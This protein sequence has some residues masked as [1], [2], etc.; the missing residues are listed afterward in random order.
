MANFSP[1]VIKLAQETERKYGVPA[2]VTLAQYALESGYGTSKVA[3]TKN[4]YFG[5][6]K[7]NGD[8]VTYQS[9]ADS[10]DSHG[11]LLGTNK[12]YT[13]KTAGVTSANQYVKAIAGTYA[14]DP[15]YYNKIVSIMRSNN[16]YQYDGGNYTVEGYNTTAT[17][18]NKSSGGWFKETGEAVLG[19]I[20]KALA[21]ILVCILAV[22]FFMT[23]FDVKIPTPGKVAESND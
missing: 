11:R 3:K 21:I 5:V 10:F 4:N 16:L 6:R 12:I 17:T 8:Y 20:I 23:A 22:V 14:D 18:T 1:E 2:S 13:S 7:A 9:M 15:S 19:G